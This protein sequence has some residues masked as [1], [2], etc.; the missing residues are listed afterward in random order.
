[1]TSLLAKNIKL[2][3]K[4][5]TCFLLNMTHLTILWKSKHFSRSYKRKR[6]W[7]FFC[8]YSVHAVICF[9]LRAV[10]VVRRQKKMLTNHLYR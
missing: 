9:M 4:W 3:Q 6:E 5:N 1:M 7:V 10:L 2:F 8:Q